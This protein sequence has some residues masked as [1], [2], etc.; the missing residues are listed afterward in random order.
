M[1]DQVTRL[2]ALVPYLQGRQGVPVSEVAEQFGITPRQLRRDLEVLWMCGLPGMLPDDMI[3]ID[4]DAVESEGV[5]YLT[6]ADVLSAPLRLTQDEALSLTLAL[7]A[8]RDLADAETSGAVES[9]L[10]KLRTAVGE[11]AI[12]AVGAELASA[13]VDVRTVLTS[14][15]A[16]HRRVQLSYDGLR[17]ASEPVVE[18]ATIFVRD[19]IAYLQAFSLE[20]DDWR[21]Y[22]LERIAAAT[23]TG[24]SFVPRPTPP[25]GDSWLDTLPFSADVTLVLG[26]SA[27]WVAEYYPVKEVTETDGGLRVVLGVMDW[28]WLTS[29]LLRLGAGVVGVEPAEA[30]AAARSS[31]RAALGRYPVESAT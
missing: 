12:D 26:P 1:S 3:E 20:A 29:L 27:R 7:T 14:A 2:L 9:A 4:M 31:A 21:T 17:R 10:A 30:A 28:P 8:A 5:V 18:P 25:L 15:I 16:E 24:Q 22:R 23:A 13:P 11:R 6:N 19:G